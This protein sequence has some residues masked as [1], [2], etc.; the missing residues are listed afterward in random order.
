MNKGTLYIISAPSGAGKTSLVK[1]LVADVDQLLVST[2][3]TTRPQR[4]GEIDGRDYHFVP[5][6]KFKAMLAQQAFLEHARVFDHF[7]GTAQKSVTDNLNKGMD[8]ILEIDWQGAQQVR[9][10]LQGCR[11]IFILPPSTAVLEQ[12]LQNRGQD[13]EAVIKRRMKDAVTEISHYPEYDYIVVND[14]FEDALC[15][16]KNIILAQRLKID[17]QQHILE[18]LLSDLLNA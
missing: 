6:E 10:L 13:S 4:P 7:Y 8:V 16:L 3:H 9:A 1:Q 12:R 18:P 2:S 11:S 17:R 5:L 15:S 14:Q